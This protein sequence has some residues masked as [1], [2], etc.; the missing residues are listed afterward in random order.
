MRAPVDPPFNVT[1]SLDKY[2]KILDYGS[3]HGGLS[4]VA[5]EKHD[6]TNL[7][8]RWDGNGFGPA[9]FR[10]GRMAALEEYDVFGRDLLK[11][12]IPNAAFD[13][14]NGVEE[15]VFFAEF[16]GDKSFSGEHVRDDPK[17]L[18]PIDLWIKGRGFMPPKEF[19]RTFG[20]EPVYIGKLTTKFVEDIRKGRLGVN[21][22]VVCK[23]GDW[24]SIWC[25]KVKTDAWLAK[26]GEP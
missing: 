14:C 18:H 7:A 21:E 8:W 12:A 10:S 9:K 26:G 11:L 1:E 2:P 20:V 16:R 25:C 24:G 5:F 6:G 19:S 23:G 22:G 3:S 17:T 13:A 15:A 4:C